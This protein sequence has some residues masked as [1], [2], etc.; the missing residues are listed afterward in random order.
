[1]EPSDH[2]VRSLTKQ[3]SG[4][5]FLLNVESTLLGIGLLVAAAGA[6]AQTTANGPC[7]ATPARDGTMPVD[8]RFVVLAK[9]NSVAVLDR[10]TGLVR[11]RKPQT[12]KLE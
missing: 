3:S 8:T 5:N 9:F 6:T 10:E 11:V 7:H 4:S 12:Q 1:M 2:P